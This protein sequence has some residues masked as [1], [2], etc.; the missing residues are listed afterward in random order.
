M[1]TC[2]LCLGQRDLMLS[3]FMPKAAFKSLRSVLTKNPNPTMVTREVIVRT[4]YQLTDYV[5]CSECENRFSFH[6]ERWVLPRIATKS[7][8]PLL[9]AVRNAPLIQKIP[10]ATVHDCSNNPNID[11][12]RLSYFAMS[13]F[14]RAATHDWK[15]V[16]KIDLGPYEEKV[17]AYLAG[18]AP[19][20]QH[21]ALL[22]TVAPNNKDI[23]TIIPPMAFDT[24]A[25]HTFIFYVPGIEFTL[26]V[27]KAISPIMKKFC[28]QTVGDH[29]IGISAGMPERLHFPLISDLGGFPS[30]L[31]R[32]NF[33]FIV[34]F[35]SDR[36]KWRSLRGINLW[37]GRIY[38]IAMLPDGRPDTVVPESFRVILRQYLQHREVKSLAPDGSACVSST[39]GLLRRASIYAGDVVPIGKESDRSWEQG[40]DPSMLDFKL[41]EYGKR[42]NLFVAEPADRKR[43]AQI[44]VRK[45]MRRSRLT[46]KSVYAILEGKPVRSATLTIFKQTI[47][48]IV[49]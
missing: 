32:A 35:E 22:V 1:G 8:F 3:H 25:H 23:F 26:C 4:S 37:N 44:G 6:G 5:L 20:P 42:T 14:W 19:F 48:G 36:R 24:A 30:G 43:W 7:R 2:K 33:N 41:K 40:E 21:V 13:V 16:S 9:D 18:S 49:T 17:R 47:D 11:I 12:A 15:V 39:C 28:V 10:N 46:Q 27:G 38:R 45:L 29:P 34:P 31:T